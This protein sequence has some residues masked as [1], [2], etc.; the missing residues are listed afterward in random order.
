MRT[1]LFDDRNSVIHAVFGYILAMLSKYGGVVAK[2]L[3]IIAFILFVVYEA[4][5]P[6]NPSSTVGDIEEFIVGFV[7][8]LMW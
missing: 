3:S 7:I 2:V 6:E 4:N 8:G 1:Y 5:E